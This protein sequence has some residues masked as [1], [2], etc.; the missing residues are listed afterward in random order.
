VWP[1]KEGTVSEGIVAVAL[2]IADDLWNQNQGEVQFFNAATGAFLGKETVGNLPDMVTFSPDGTKVLTA[3]EGEPNEDYSF[4]PEGSISIIDLTNGVE[5]AQIQEATF[6]NINAQI[7]DLK[8]EG[9]RIFGPHATVAQ[10]L[11]PEYVTFSGDGQKAWVTLQENNAI[12]VV[13]IATATVESIKPLGFKDHSL[14]NNS[15]DVSDRDGGINI[16]NWPIFGIYEPD[17][18][19]SYTVDGQTYY[20]TANEGDARVRPSDDGILAGQD[21]GDIYNEEIR[22]G[23][24]SYILDP[25]AFPQGAELKLSENLGRLTVTNTLGQSDRAVFVSELSGDQ[26]FTP[27]ETTATGSS[28]A[29]IDD[30]GFLQ[31]NLT[32]SNLDFGNLNGTPLT[33]I[34]SDNVTLLH[35]HQGVRG[36]NGGVVWNIL[37]D[38]DTEIT[39]AEDGTATITSVWQENTIPKTN[40]GEDTTFYFNVHTSGNPSG[41]IRGQLM[42]EV[43]YD[44]IYAF[45]GRSFTIWDSNGNLVYDSGNDFEQITAAQFPSLFNSQGQTDNFDTRSDN[46][47]PEPEG[48][49]VGTIDGRTYAFVGLERIGGVMVYDVTNPTAP[50]FV[51]YKAGMEDVGP[52]GLTFISGENSPHGRPLLVVTNEESNTTSIFEINVPAPIVK[53]IAFIAGEN[54]E[55]SLDP[56]NFSK[57]FIDPQN[58]PLNTVKIT[59]LPENGTLKLSGVEVVAGAEINVTD[60]ANL[61]FTPAA[62]FNGQTSFLWNGSDGQQYANKEAKVN[63]RV[64]NVSGTSTELD[65]RLIGDKNDNLLSGAGG[66]DI[67]KGNRGNDTLNGGDGNDNLNGGLGDDLIDG[68]TGVDRIIGQGNFDFTLTDTSLTGQGT[69][70]FVNI[71]KASLFGGQ[72]DNLLNAET[73]TLGDVVLWGNDG[74]DTLKGGDGVDF[75]YGG[76]END[77]LYGGLGQD[78][79]FGGDDAD[80]FVLQANGDRDIIK[81]FTN[82]EDKLGLVNGLEFGQLTITG[83]NKG[84]NTLIT[85]DQ[86]NKLAL[87]E[88]VNP[89]SIDVSDFVTM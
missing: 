67:L 44:E 9:V 35:I 71:E 82:G 54:S 39:I 79:L 60:L 37:G 73:F 80:T 86:G 34:T 21:E 29:W 5:N 57:N 74:N 7:E 88:N 87:L 63:L 38:S 40:Q 51:E 12:A 41:E 48:V 14:P 65:D 85:D 42:G 19:A 84:N 53:N 59:T 43:A 49:T 78:R 18:I 55:I 56:S 1:G 22:V 17:T 11:E 15:L 23:N 46:K 33:E 68:G 75:L 8:A 70:T 28:L 66:N 3:N 36:A 2:A 25:V 26:E 6:T 13:D 62:D 50:N 27:V 4:D 24:A 89:S 16:A 52:E 61:T 58:D 47:G 76:E 31:I 81:D 20:V 30:N 83:L 32:I 77:L 69:D 72:G 64:M 45:G 10:D